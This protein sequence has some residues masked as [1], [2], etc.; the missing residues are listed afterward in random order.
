MGHF[1]RSQTAAD[2]T[3]TWALAGALNVSMIFHL[4][5]LALGMMLSQSLLPAAARHLAVLAVCGAA[6]MG[7]PFAA[8]IWAKAQPVRT[9]LALLGFAGVAVWL[10]MLWG[11]GPSPLAGPEDG[12]WLRDRVVRFVCVP[13]AVLASAGLAVT[14]PLQG[15]LAEGVA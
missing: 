7:G 6:M 4:A 14:A 15:L 10:S 9:P 5:L 8:V 3:E 11:V 12:A 1:A 2:S 13:V